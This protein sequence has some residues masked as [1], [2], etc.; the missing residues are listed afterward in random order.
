MI[1]R[2]AARIRSML[3]RRK[4]LHRRIGPETNLQLIDVTAF[5]SE[6]D[7]GYL[8]VIK[9]APVWMTRAERLLLYTL[10]FTLR[11]NRYLEIGTFQGGSALV[12]AAAMDALESPG[13]MVCVDP[14]PK[15]DPKNWERLQHRATL[16]T[17]FS[18][19]IL[20]QAQEAAGGPFDFA[21]I[22]GDHTYEGLVRDAKGVFTVCI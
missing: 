16:L 8:E 20:P 6:I 3:H 2:A 4:G 7:L 22:D 14:E 19:Q 5:A 17:G 21:L 15:I 10:I 13:R 1:N 12:A 11:P 9:W 18:P